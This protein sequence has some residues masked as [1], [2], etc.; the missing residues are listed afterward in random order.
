MTIYTVLCARLLY[1]DPC[2]SL[3]YCI[4]WHIARGKLYNTAHIMR[5]TIYAIQYDII[6]DN[7][8]DLR[9]SVY[10]KKPYV[11]KP[12]Y[13]LLANVYLV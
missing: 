10:G 2:E 7:Y 6:G 5:I 13:Y 12:Y 8:S 1:C 3:F 4:K 9:C 11:P